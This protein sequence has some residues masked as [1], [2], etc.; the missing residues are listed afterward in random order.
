MTISRRQ[1]LVGSGAVVGG[2]IL[3]GYM[4]YGT[5]ESN[6]NERASKL[7]EHNGAELLAGW[8]T[9][10]PDDVTT[11][12]IPHADFGQ[13]THPA[14]AMMLADELDADC[15]KVRAEQAPGDD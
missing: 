9:I 4:A 6:T 8:V 10:A 3:V 12:L 2:G 13:G 7:T 15:A 5:A 1:L 11:V 14:L